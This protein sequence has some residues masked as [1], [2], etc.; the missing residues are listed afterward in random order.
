MNPFRNTIVTDPWNPGEIDVYGINVNAFDLCCN[1]LNRVRSEGRSTSVLL[2]GEAGSG[3]THLLGRLQKHLR[4]LSQLH[5]FVSVSLQSSPGGLWRHIRKSFVESLMRPVSQKR[6]QLELVFVYRLNQLLGEEFQNKKISIK[7]LRQFTRMLC[8]EA[9]LSWNLGK[10]IEH[11]LRKKR[12]REAIAWLKGDSL[13]ESVY[14]ELDL[15]SENEEITNPEDGA[16]EVVKEL[17]RLAGADIQLVVCFDQVEAIQRYPGDNKG[18][19]AFGQAIQALHDETRNV[20]IVSC[21]QSFFLEFLNK[22][23]MKPNYNRLTVHQGTLNPLILGQSLRLVSDRLQN[24][25][26]LFEDKDKIFYALKQELEQSFHLLMEMW[27][28]MQC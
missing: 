1:A 7:K 22:V 18:V 17:C 10:V 6:S 12:Q 26:E 24:S 21:I 13:P 4:E 23:M 11:M 2:F 19:F 27:K 9:D 15:V 8:D 14:Q 3:K 28:S 5:V 16:R 25:P 20:L